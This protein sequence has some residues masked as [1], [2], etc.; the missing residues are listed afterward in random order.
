MHSHY[1]FGDHISGGRET[2]DKQIVNQMGANA[3]GGKESL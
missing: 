1:Y 2:K 3:V